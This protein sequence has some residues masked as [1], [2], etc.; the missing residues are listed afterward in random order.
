MLLS[1]NAEPIAIIGR[2]CHLPGAPNLRAY[3]DLIL[4]D[5]PTITEI[6]AERFDR[7]LFFDAEPG[8]DFKTYC[9]KACLVA[10]VSEEKR[11]NLPIQWKNHPETALRDLLSVAR[12]ACLDAGRPLESFGGE[13]GGVYIG[14]TRGGSISGDLA[15]SSYVAQA[16]ALLEQLPDRVP[17]ID[18]SI[19]IRW[20]DRLIREVRGAM[21]H[22]GEGSG[23]A[24]GAPV[25][26]M[27]TLQMFGWDGPFA[28][29]NG[30]CASSLQ[31]LH[32][33]VLALQSGRIDI[34]V[35]AGL[36]CYHSDSL[37]LFAQ[38]RSLS[39]TDTR[40][41]DDAADGLIIGEGAVVLLLKRLSDALRDSDPVHGVIR[42]IAVASD[43][44]G[45]SLWAPRKEGQML[46]VR[47]AYS[48][49]E[50]MKRIQYIEAHATSTQVG[51]A[52]EMEAL[53]NVF[54]SITPEGT[55]IP[56]GSVKAIVGHTLESAGL[57]GVLKTLLCMERGLVPAHQRIG[58]LSSNIAWDTIPF[59]VPTRVSEWPVDNT[60]QRWAAVNG[61]GIGGLNAH[62]VIQTGNVSASM[63]P[64][65][66]KSRPVI[67]TSKIAIIGA[68]CILPGALT[69]EQFR[70]KIHHDLNGLKSIPEKRWVSG[71]EQQ[72]TFQYPSHRVCGGFIDDFE[73]D[74]RRH[75]VQPKQI[76]GASPLQFMILE[77]VDQ[78]IRPSGIL[79]D[80]T[81][82]ERTGVV[83][84]TIFG[85]DFSNQLQ[86][87][88]RIPD[89]CRRL[90]RLWAEEGQSDASIDHMISVFQALVLERMPAF[91]DET[92]SFT[93][94]SLA[95]RITKSFDLMGGAVA[96]DA[97]HGASGA[98]LAYCLDQL[99]LGNADHMI[100]IGAQ[101]DM[102]P[103]K[104]EGWT[105]NGWL[106]KVDSPNEDSSSG[107]FPG[108]G[109]AVILL[110]AV[111][112][113]TAPTAR[114]LG[115]IRGIGHCYAKSGYT[116]VRV[117]LDRAIQSSAGTGYSSQ[118][119]AERASGKTVSNWFSPMGVDELDR[120]CQFG[121]MH[122]DA[123]VEL[124]QSAIHRV[125]HLTGGSGIVELLAC[126]A[127][128]AGK[129]SVY[130]QG[131][132]KEMEIYS[133]DRITIGSSW[134]CI[135][136]VVLDTMM[137]K[138]V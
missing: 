118:V 36:S 47:R 39:G 37:L 111:R 103:M 125:G 25:A 89:M 70:K 119:G 97:A 79:E 59:H 31:A 136:S 21:P 110:E 5:T 54:R 132:G 35:A 107:A 85:G 109:A 72:G 116:S 27:A 138:H 64:S 22:R 99:S 23:P 68:G 88:L 133:T 105:S 126:L 66:N 91:F 52:T 56:V 11:R 63:N 26:A 34:A 14:H 42:G 108:E 40:P 71:P 51:D 92:G 12:D 43:G 57:A 98:A 10:P 87:G 18:R 41:F 90:R 48:C 75:K 67:Q 129:A 15:Y 77:A 131:K 80:A 38:A 13:L 16:A 120:P 86:V 134:E 112:Q 69:W 29:F 124:P 82:R 102:G 28:A 115:W 19:A 9:S 73:Y 74:W 4:S 24:L 78:A 93:S 94:S 55:R 6:P 101:Q 114:P 76:K 17:G 84:G 32:A 123:N 60:G 45:K 83:V 117:S 135:Y 33:A 113:G 2:G 106:P 81:K 95:S 49:E 20:R 130:G 58:S 104:F 8:K 46:A 137:E 128:Q 96:V 121:A 62:A 100:C 50:M 3:L 44:K 65:N 127:I 1:Q 30:A 61:F 7:S 122:A 53:A